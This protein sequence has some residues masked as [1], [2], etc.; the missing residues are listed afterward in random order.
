[1]TSTCWTWKWSDKTTVGAVSLLLTLSITPAQY[2]RIYTPG[3]VH[4]LTHSAKLL[5]EHIATVPMLASKD[6]FRKREGG[7][8][9]WDEVHWSWWERWQCC[10]RWYC[11]SQVSPRAVFVFW[12]EGN[13]KGFDGE[14]CGLDRLPVLQT[15]QINN[16]H[17]KEEVA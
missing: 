5:S 15:L 17:L 1:M 13:H 10:R 2:I 8:G 14:W 12:G 6:V 11:G 3:R 9:G 4:V 7:T 16:E